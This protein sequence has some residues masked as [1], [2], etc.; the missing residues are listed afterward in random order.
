MTRTAAPVVLLLR[1][2]LSFFLTL[3]GARAHQVD[4]VEF[5]FQ[6]LDGIWRLHGEMDIAYMLPETRWVPDAGP[7]SRRELTKAP[8][9]ELQRIRRETENTL[10]QHLTFRHAGKLLKWR[11]E[12]P[13]FEKQPFALPEE[14]NDWA[15]LTVRL[16]V[17]AQ[18]VPGDFSVHWSKQEKATLII[19][20]EDSPDGEI[21]AVEPGDSLTLLRVKGPARSAGGAKDKAPAEK[22][23]VEKV[24]VPAFRS[25]LMNGFRHVLPL[26]LDHIFFIF[27]LFVAVLAL[28]PMLWQSLLFTLAHSLTL[29]LCALEIVTIQGRW[30]EIF[31]ALSIAFTGLENL[32]G[33]KVGR[34][35][36]ITVFLF[37]L[38][39]GM[40][41]A[42][43]F[44]EQ[45]RS[46]PDDQLLMPLLGFNLGVEM[47]QVTVI[48]ISAVV[49]AALPKKR[50]KLGQKIASLL[51][52]AFGLIW[53][54]QRIFQVDLTWG[55]M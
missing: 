45:V 6:R 20:T 23:E 13:D 55:L 25:W 10:R 46:V 53:M 32:L 30:V 9:S 21:V 3:A 11:I 27:G 15:L 33:L 8:A 28:R 35:R 47:A 50:R 49:F 26:G 40:G 41:F 19:L 44:A 42:S 54:A 48:L 18:H 5:E 22:W 43:V 12:F 52:L 31:I 24:E 7:L 17:E 37:G 39:H 34:R 1:L 38:V 16:V 4:T 29:G 2:F 51:V 36:Y 14:Y